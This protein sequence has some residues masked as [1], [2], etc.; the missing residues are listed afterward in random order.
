MKSSKDKRKAKLYK[1]WKRYLSDSRLNEDE[2]VR[3]A[4][5]FTKKGMKAPEEWAVAVKMYNQ[6][7]TATRFIHQKDTVTVYI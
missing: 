4:K 6:Q 1:K 5:S 2:I 7:C 3:R